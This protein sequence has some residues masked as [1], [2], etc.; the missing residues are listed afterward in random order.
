MM[1]CRC[2]SLGIALFLL[3]TVSMLHKEKKLHNNNSMP[4]SI[5]LQS[6]TLYVEK[7]LAKESA[8]GD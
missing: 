6:R 4:L 2:I 5:P 1:D 8:L 7:Y 3:L